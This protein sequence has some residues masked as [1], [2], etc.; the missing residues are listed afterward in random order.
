MPWVKVSAAI[1][2]YAGKVCPNNEA[3]TVDKQSCIR[4]AWPFGGS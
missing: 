2:D 1:F 3:R 4:A